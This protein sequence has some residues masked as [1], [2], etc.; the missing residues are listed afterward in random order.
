MQIAA[1]ITLAAYRHTA[2]RI[3]A[4]MTPTDI[5]AIMA[6]A[7]AALGGK[8]GFELILPGEAS[9][10]PHGSGKPQAV[11]EG[12]E[13][14]RAE[15]RERVRQDGESRGVARTTKNKKNKKHRNRK[16]N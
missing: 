13:I 6:A 12:E 5:G 1:D 10:Y 3:E 8:G 7:T 2:P 4:G 11:R 15:G 14:G 16:T 9:A